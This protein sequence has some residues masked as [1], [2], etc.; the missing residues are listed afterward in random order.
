M[1][2]SIIVIF[3]E[4]VINSN[5][6]TACIKPGRV[7]AVLEWLVRLLNLSYDVWSSA[8][9]TGVVHVKVPLCKGKGDK[10]DVVTRE[11]LVC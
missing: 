9:W 2:L 7:I 8:Y 6:K 3:D 4:F 1:I 5:I 11:V 10:H